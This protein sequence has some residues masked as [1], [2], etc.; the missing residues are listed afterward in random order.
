MG[1]FSNAPVDA[2]KVNVP[3]GFKEVEHP[4]KKGLE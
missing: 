1:N 2:A 3:P 4:M